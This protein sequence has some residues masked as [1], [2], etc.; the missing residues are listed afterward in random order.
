MLKKFIEKQYFI[1]NLDMMD[2]ADAMFDTDD[3]TEEEIKK[4]DIQYLDELLEKDKLNISNLENSRA[5]IKFNREERV[6]YITL[7]FNNK[8]YKLSLLDFLEY[9]KYKKL[10][11]YFL[12]E[13]EVVLYNFS[14]QI[15]GII[16]KNY[17]FKFMMK[18]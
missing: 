5:K 11:R 7:N 3:Q 13:T 2:I 14:Y 9:N 1:I 18:I 10:T 6:L 16:D 8:E 15:G 12:A 17:G 4:L